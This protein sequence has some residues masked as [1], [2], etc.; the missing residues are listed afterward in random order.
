MSTILT[1][2]APPS[3]GTPPRELGSRRR[4]I[5]LALAG[6]AL[7]V[8]SVLFAMRGFAFEALLTNRHP[9]ILAFWLPQYCF[10]GKSLAAGHIPAW[11]PF[12]FTGTPFAADPQSGWL[13]AP[14]MLLF[15]LF[16]CGTALRMF[17]V[18]QPLLAGLGL[19]WFLRK[20]SL[21]RLAAT[22]G[23]LSIAMM[24][25]A[26]QIGISLPFAGTLAWTPY[27]LVGA[28]GYLST[29]RW[30]RRLGWMALGAFAWG[31]V[32]NAHMSHGLAMC[33][34]ITAA[35]LAVRSVQNVRRGRT[36]PLR[37]AGMAIA[38]L[39]FLPL[40]TLAVFIP[41]LAV[42]SRS[43]LRGG[44][45]A[46]GARLAQV[47]GIHDRPLMTNGVFSGW[48]FVVG[49][50]PGAYAGAVTLLALPLALRTRRYRYLAA[51]FFLTGVVAYVLTLNALIAASWFRALVLRLPFGDV[52][53]HNPGRLRYLIFLVVPVLGA[54]GIQGLF[55]RPLRSVRS[56][57]LWLG[58][59]AVMFL[60]LPLLFGANAQ[61]YT[62]LAIG[63][64]ISA[65]LLLRVGR[66]S[67]APVAVVGVLAVELFAGAVYSQV[68]SGGTVFL[69]LEG[70]D[71]PNLLA[72]PLRWP[73]VS[74]DDYTTPGP[75][76]RYLQT[77]SGRYLTWAPEAV[78]FEKGYLFNQEEGDWP[79]LT[80][81]RGTLFGIEDALGYN[82][83]QLPRY[84]SYVRA[85]DD[86]SIFYNASVLQTPTLQN[87]RLLGVRYLVVPQGLSPPI[88]GR[89]VARQYGYDLYEVS[90]WQPQ[91]SLVPAW[92]AAPDAA[93]ALRQ[94]LDPGFDPSSFA[95]VEQD[96]AIPT[97]VPA[98]PD[99]NASG[100][101]KVHPVGNQEIRIAVDAQ[102]PA[103][104]V[105]R[106]PYDSG[107]HATVNG[108]DAPILRA[109]YFLQAVSVPAG[110][111]RV[112]LAYDDPRI[113]EGLLA[114][115]IVWLALLAAF[116]AAV[117]MERRRF[118]RNEVT[119][120]ATRAAAPPDGSGA[121]EPSH[122]PLGS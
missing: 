43:S 34:L 118:R 120:T 28:S 53:L 18:L 6:P 59:G 96:P 87:A 94:V 46:L 60:G 51:G 9:D 80:D 32:A 111:S 119:P 11:N 13:Y 16:S 50:S 113:G 22:A 106:V 3:A 33:T 4:R 89:V 39:V 21:H 55:E 98:S 56:A 42:I 19:Y 64:A 84:W 78:Y 57:V 54:L 1:Q 45:A 5:G 112:T 82:P 40:A 117:L 81:G 14:A 93:G 107:W 77:H 70:S 75:I 27:V 102:E 90:G 52:Y 20:E 79:A 68:Y 66:R 25:A 97:G 105:V 61:R 69:G 86:L 74:V 47:A 41:R 8:G 36:R 30:P 109:D 122:P 23:G 116:G 108:A 104:L 24:I 99:G 110:S 2:G 103:L 26:S 85:T 67:W 101:A 15:S 48:P 17:I 62:L 71:H 37:A 91:A 12:Q 49:S 72:G 121:P 115:G 38:F 95:V 58:A 65:P 73:D 7:I 35:Y 63:V 92:S 114:S 44:Y 76:A 31:Q 100:A 29:E 10:L 88:A 83:L